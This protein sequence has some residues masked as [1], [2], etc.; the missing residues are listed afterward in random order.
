MVK[1]FTEV[2]D[3]GE[4]Q[5]FDTGS[6]RDTDA[7]KG[8]PHLI[9]GEP[10]LRVKQYHKSK[11]TCYETSFVEDKEAV[12]SEIENC[13]WE[14]TQLV[15]NREDNI[16]KL[17]EALQLTCYLIALDEG[18]PYNHIYC[19][20]NRLAIHY[21]NGAKKYDANNWRLGQPVSRYFD[22]ANRHLWKILANQTDEDHYAALLWNLVAIIQT[23]IDVERGLLPQELDDYPFTLVEVFDR[24]KA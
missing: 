11:G 10:F 23:K 4:R 8:N 20:Y 2:K 21:Q 13:L 9:A 19:A 7:G 24:K 22:S 18:K 5:Q 3:S 17:Y 16:G 6:K 12:A 1:Q 15:Q 14:Y